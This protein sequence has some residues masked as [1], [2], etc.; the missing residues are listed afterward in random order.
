MNEYEV[1]KVRYINLPGFSDDRK[2]FSEDPH[3]TLKCLHLETTSK[4]C[5]VDLSNMAAS[6][7]F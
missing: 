5:P 6:T 1:A 7:D 4:R 3:G 2:G